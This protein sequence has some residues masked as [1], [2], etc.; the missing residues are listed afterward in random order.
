MADFGSGK[1]YLTFA[2][3]DWL[4]AQGKQARVTGVELREDMVRLCNEAARRHGHATACASTWAMC[5]ATSRH[6]WT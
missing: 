5:A 3:H 1:G 4:R 2:M 6:G